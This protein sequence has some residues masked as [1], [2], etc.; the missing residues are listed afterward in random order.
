MIVVSDTTPTNFYVT[1]D[2]LRESERRYHKRK[3]AQEQDEKIQEPTVPT[4]EDDQWQEDG[5]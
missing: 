2:V 1:D 3:E 4:S 5:E